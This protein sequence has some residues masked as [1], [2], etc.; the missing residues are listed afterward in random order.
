[1]DLLYWWLN[2]LSFDC[3][4]QAV[5]GVFHSHE[6][7]FLTSLSQPIV[8]KAGLGE[9][10][11][12]V[13]FTVHKEKP[14]KGLGRSIVVFQ[15][16]DRVCQGNELEAIFDLSSEK[17]LADSPDVGFPLGYELVE[18][19]RK[20]RW[21]KTTH[22]GV[23]AIEVDAELRRTDRRTRESGE[24]AAGGPSPDTKTIWIDSELIRVSADITN[25]AFDIDD[26]S[27]KYRLDA[28]T[29]F[30]TDC[31]IPRRGQG[32]LHAFPIAAANPPPSPSTSVYPENDRQGC[33][34]FARHHDIEVEIPIAHGVIDD[35]STS[36]DE[37][38]VWL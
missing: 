6:I 11:R 19:D 32:Y 29:I 23:D 30:D 26:L 8:E 28:E 27:R 15:V 18:D 22:H 34:M 24:M 14:R 12:S 20:I 38:F 5:P 21:T 4:K 10:N 16:A 25:G 1:M 37:L 7:R 13:E 33:L 9:R 3:A 36:F 35:F 17:D 2:F 31:T